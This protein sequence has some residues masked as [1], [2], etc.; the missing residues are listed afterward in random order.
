M[1][2]KNLSVI[3]FLFSLFFTMLVFGQEGSTP[4]SS[5]LCATVSCSTV[6]VTC[7]DGFVASCQ[8]TCDPATGS[9][10]QC[11][12]DCTGH[13]PEGE[14]A[15]IA[16][17]EQLPAECK[18]EVDET[19]IERVTC[20]TTTL[21]C[22]S[23]PVELKEK[24]VA[25]GGNAVEHTDPSGCSY[26]SC[27]YEEAT[28]TP[29]PLIGQTQCP[30]PEEIE[31]ALNKCTGL[32]LRGVVDLAGG[33]KVPV[34]VPREER[35][36]PV[37]TEEIRN[38]VEEKCIA[39]GLRPIEDFDNNGCP[40]LRC[41][42]RDF[43]PTDIPSEASEKCQEFGG[44]FIVKRNEA[45][46]IVY[47]TCL[48]RGDE[49]LTYVERP[50]RIPDEPVLLGI[51]LKLENL[52]IELDRLM[53]EAESIADYYAS[54]NDPSEERFRRA[55]DMFRAAIEKVDEIKEELRSELGRLTVED[56]IEIKHGIRYIKEVLLKEITYVMLSTNED[57][58]EIEA[59]EVDDCRNDGLCFERAFRIC[60]PV[61]FRPE[62]F[63]N[64]EIEIRGLEN[65][66]CI[67]FARMSE[68]PK[69]PVEM[70]CR[71]ENYALGI[72]GPE[73]IL[74]FCEGSMADMMRQF[75]GPAASQGIEFPPPEGG[76][77]GCRTIRE[78]AEFCQ[79][80]YE[81]C[82]QWMK[83]HPAYSSS[84]SREEFQRIASEEYGGFIGPGGCTTETECK[85]YCSQETHF[86]ECRRFAIEQGFN[87][88]PTGEFIRG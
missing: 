43:C 38:Q 4:P 69:G 7:P 45:G 27:E 44:E 87:K 81:T 54:I 6:S 55:V 8:Q 42:H 56:M 29:N 26:V 57:V 20:I 61:R 10:L 82:L 77:G 70:T 53:R 36:C 80:N 37:I 40:L 19:G 74:P 2:M 33:C 18:K 67:L 66:K 23:F 47:A 72:T 51:A 60:K 48:T 65:G 71:I 62:G 31:I 17:P 63:G 88:L 52:R 86:E 12:P 11:F 3:T 34:C 68:G 73:D 78:C 41:E 9:C 46:C 21:T 79:Q 85:E 32:G 49:R 39:E 16:V 1:F 35:L 64:P 59:G 58:E 5:D 30:K 75:G 13:I 22:P 14:V 15:I 76:P 50:E 24:C 28:I 83:E 84:T 25:E